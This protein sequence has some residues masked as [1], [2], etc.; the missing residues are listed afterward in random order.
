[1]RKASTDHWYDVA[2]GTS[3]AH[4][5]INLISKDGVIIV[6]TYINDSKELYD[7][8]YAHKEEIEEQLGFPL[9]WNRL[10]SKKA[11]RIK[12]SI[13]G[14]NFDDHSN[15]NDLMNETIDVVVKMRDVFKQYI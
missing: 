9:E 10:D 1:M 11:S 8:L 14:L 5:G 6:E 3:E 2:L 7:A 4:I 12:Y 15:Y 13:P